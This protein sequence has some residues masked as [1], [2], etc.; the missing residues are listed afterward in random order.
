V[1]ITAYDF[2]QQLHYLLFYREPRSSTFQADCSSQAAKHFAAPSARN[3]TSRPL[4]SNAATKPAANIENENRN[5]VLVRTSFK[6][7]FLVTFY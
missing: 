1:L 7:W 5:T 2:K 4:P 3:A 6:K